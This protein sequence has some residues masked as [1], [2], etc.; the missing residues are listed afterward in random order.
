MSRFWLST[1]YS[2]VL[3]VLV[4]WEAVGRTRVHLHCH[5]YL[6]SV[7]CSWNEPESSLHFTLWFTLHGGV[8]PWMEWFSN[9]AEAQDVHPAWC[10]SHCTS[11]VAWLRGKCSVCWTIWDF[12]WSLAFRNTCGMNAELA[13]SVLLYKW[14]FHVTLVNV[15]TAYDCYRWLAVWL[16]L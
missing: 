5:S 9:K 15:S 16:Q 11:C 8:S 6:R 12:V 13:P 4:V 7:E 10:T 14:A 2:T 3:G 1:A